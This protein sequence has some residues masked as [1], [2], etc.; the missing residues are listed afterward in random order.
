MIRLLTVVALALMSMAAKNHGQNPHWRSDACDACHVAASPAAGDSGPKSTAGDVLCSAC[1]APGSGFECRHQSDVAADDAMR[2]RMPESFRASLDEDRLTCTTCHEL[3]AQCIDA[4]RAER[5]ANPMFLRDG[6]FRLRGDPCFLCHDENAYGKLDVH[7]QMIE[8][9][10]RRD[11][12]C[13][14]CHTSVDSPDG[15]EVERLAVDP[16]A[17]L[18][19]MCTGC[20][21]IG[22][23]PGASFTFSG[24]ATTSHLVE[25]TD[26]MRRRMDGVADRDGV[27]LP[28]DPSSG[29]IYCATCHDPHDGRLPEFGDAGQAHRLRMANICIACHDI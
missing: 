15:A 23:H 19:A 24:T 4:R 27:R 7:D 18:N 17:D 25:P 22:P 9:G 21:A 2:S 1:H 5:S 6:P 10:R 12:V 26:S 13:L 11:P 28:L 16:G 8:N 14:V 29:K 20:H 3:P